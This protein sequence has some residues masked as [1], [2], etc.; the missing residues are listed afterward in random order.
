MKYLYWALWGVYDK[1]PTFLKAVISRLVYRP[2]LGK[3]ARLCGWVIF[4]ANVEIGSGTFIRGGGNQFL[5]HVKIG[6]FCC[7]ASGLSVGLT[8]HPYEAFSSYRM[9]NRHSPLRGY[10]KKQTFD[11]GV[12]QTTTGNDVWIGQNVTIKDGVTIGDGA[13]IG[14]ASVVTKDV[15]PFAVVAGVPARVIKYRFDEEKIKLMQTIK[16]WDWEPEKIYDELERLNEFDPS[17]LELI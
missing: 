10:P 16:W 4:S 1:C 5:G 13:V 9:F 6:K 3:G 11:V 15:P 8:R 12:Q 2:K 14:A 17:L 7:I